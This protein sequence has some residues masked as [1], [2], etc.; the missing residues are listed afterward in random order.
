[1]GTGRSIKVNF[2][3]NLL[4]TILGVIFPIITIPYVSRVLGPEGLGIIGFNQSIVSYI[5]IFSSLGIATYAVREVSRLKNN[6][7]EQRICVLEIL[8]LHLLLTVLAYIA[9]ALLYLFVPAIRATGLVF[10]ILSVPIFFNAIGVVWFFQAREDFMFIL[11]RSLVVK[12]LSLIALFVFVKRSEDVVTYAAVI[13]FADSSN[14]LLNF[15]KLVKIIKIQNLNRYKLDIFRHV[16]PTLTIFAMGIVISLYLDLPAVFLG[17][18]NGEDSVGYF[19]TSSKLS[20]VVLSLVTAL[21]TTLLPRMS[22]YYTIGD[23]KNFKLLEQSGFKFVIGLTVPIMLAI[24]VIAP[25]IIFSFAGNEFARSVTVLR[26]LAPTIPVIG[27][28]GIIGFQSLYPQGKERI[29]IFSAISGFVVSVILNIVLTPYY[30]ENG[31]AISYL[32]AETTVTVA[33]YIIGRRY[34]SVKLLDRSIFI[35][36]IASLVMSV[37]LLLLYNILACQIGIKLIIEILA[38]LITYIIVLTIMKEPLFIKLSTEVFFRIR[39]KFNFNQE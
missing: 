20:K 26:W 7:E 35:Y 13:A 10:L 6:E 34:L 19:V 14:C 16:Y 25:D 21:G 4:N 2:T 3:L 36:V 9:V 30:A 33:M 37:I 29:I 11:V 22:H 15:I 1:M 18:V 28:A 38:G 5:T 17:F 12:I 24:I 27:I 23:Y 32:A 39:K 8:G 31:A